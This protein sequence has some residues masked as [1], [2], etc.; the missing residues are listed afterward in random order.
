MSVLFS[1]F[2]KRQTG[3]NK[4][5]KTRGKPVSP[6]EKSITGCEKTTAGCGK[7]ISAGN[8]TIYSYKTLFYPQIF[9]RPIFFAFVSPLLTKGKVARGLSQPPLL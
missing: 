3:L 4:F 7:S 9:D 5:K 1:A 2:F 6:C 8:K